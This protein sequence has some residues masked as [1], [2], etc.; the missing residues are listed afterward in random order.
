MISS[1]TILK[2]LPYV[3]KTVDIP[4]LGRKTQGK[5]RDIYFKNDKRI[6]ITTDRQSAFD[7]ILGHIPYKGAILNQLSVFWFQKTKKIVNNHLI[8]PL[9][10]NVIIVKNCQPIPVE[11]IVR[12]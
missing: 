6:L 4:F 1:K 8:T 7:V 9:D 12:G 2:A 5:V 3:L 10:P 11:M